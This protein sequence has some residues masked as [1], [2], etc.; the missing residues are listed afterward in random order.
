M[1]KGE[2]SEM[3]YLA[4]Q[5]EYLLCE[6]SCVNDSDVLHEWTSAGHSEFLSET[7]SY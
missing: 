7:Y 2:K 1:N 5:A 3:S 6:K 4:G